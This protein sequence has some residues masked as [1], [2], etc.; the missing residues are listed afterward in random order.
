MQS[1]LRLLYAEL[2]SEQNLRQVVRKLYGVFAED[3]LIGFF[4][5]QRDL[6]TIANRQSDFLLRAMGATPSYSG[7]PPATAHLEMPP[8]LTGHFDRRLTLLAQLLP[9]LGISPEGVQTWVDFEESFRSS[10]VRD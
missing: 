5:A 6:D 1:R 2:G 9:Q 8:I 4:F 3:L 7:K 10:V